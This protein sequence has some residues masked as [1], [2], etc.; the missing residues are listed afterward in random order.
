[1]VEDGAIGRE[2]CSDRGGSTFDGPA[3]DDADSLLYRMT[4]ACGSS[5]G[6][7]SLWE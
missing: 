7:R 1:M 3:P 2:E 6:D 4:G 5:T